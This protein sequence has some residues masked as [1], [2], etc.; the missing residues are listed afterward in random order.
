[1]KGILILLFTIT[2][3]ILGIAA[4]A[5]TAG[6]SGVIEWDNWAI[7]ADVSLDLAS[8][9]LKLPSGRTQAESALKQNYQK[10]I[11]PAL[12]SLRVDSSATIADLIERGDLTYSEAE[13]IAAK[14]GFIAPSLTSD[15]RRITKTHSIS[16]ADITSAL[17]RHSRAAP[18]IRTLNPIS[19]ARYTGIIIIA[20]DSLP[21]HGMKSSVL[22]VPC[23]FPKI[24]DDQ[25][26]LIFE[27]SMI[28]PS[29][30]HNTPM[31]KYTAAEN[32]FANN[33]AGL[34]PEIQKTAG[35]RPLRIFARGVFGIEP[36]DLI[37]NREDALLIISSEDNRRLLSQ[38]KVIFVLN[39]SVLRE[40]F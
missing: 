30:A 4:N 15:L 33:P 16:F 21:V 2:F 14:A 8:A 17:L 11:I 26:N 5:E 32:I 23:L 40:E 27:R 39:E 25:M 34:S 1:M 12:F 18:V 36:T 31:V 29:I 9:G 6:I 35:D 38:G 28:D 13:N 22:A 7:K 19:S 20:V 3:L 24:W 10:L 37:I